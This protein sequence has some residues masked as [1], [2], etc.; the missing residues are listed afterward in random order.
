MHELRVNR[1]KENNLAE[2]VQKQVAAVTP[3]LASDHPDVRVQGVLCFIGAEWDRLAPPFDQNGVLVTW[4]KKLHKVLAQ[5]GPLDAE[6]IRSVHSTLLRVLPPA[7][8]QR[9]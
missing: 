6:S 2:G 4:P 1:S 5:A 7:V 3:A 9:G 8:G